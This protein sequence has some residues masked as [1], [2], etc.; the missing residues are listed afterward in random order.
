M[1]FKNSNKRKVKFILLK[2]IALID[3]ISHMKNEVAILFIGNAHIQF[4]HIY[5]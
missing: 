3:F 2:Q 5:N 4:M 1:H